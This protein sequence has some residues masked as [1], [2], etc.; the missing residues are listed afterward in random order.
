M[1]VMSSKQI[2][3]HVGLPKTA[4]TFL[5]HDCFPL[6][7]GVHTASLEEESDRELTLFFQDLAY[8][9]PSFYALEEKR[10]EL[11]AL[12]ER[13]DR[14]KILISC[15]E[16]F[17]WF[18]LNF[19]NNFFIAE[20]LKQLIPGAKLMIVIRAQADWLESA[21]KQT[22]RQNSS[23]TINRFLR[24]KDGRFET[25]RLFPGRP[26]INVRELNY[27][28]Y[29]SHYARL[30]GAD[31]IMIL[32]FELVNGNQDEFMRRTAQFMDTNFVRT[33][34]NRTANRGYS[35]ITSYL[36]LVLNRFIINQYHGQGMV[37][38]QPFHAYFKARRNDNFFYRVLSSL[39]SRMNLN[40]V[41][42]HIL[43]RVIYIRA[44]FISEQKRRAIFDIHKA[45]NRALE[46][47]FQVG[48]DG[49][50]YY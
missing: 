25:R 26:Q 7:D 48:L 18:H 12:I 3:L 24:F 35:L 30:F 8:A 45:S 1:D 31:N 44:K 46:E 13:T 36:A 49:L 20:T 17:G 29:I 43:D 11:A 22:L 27:H 23:E 32:P 38:E 5:Q 37:P 42:E 6:L 33:P 2:Y 4:T 9:N 21:Y 14:E 16:L 28:T 34:S 39:T 50:G 47:E 40:Y 41:L 10:A 19:A 15:E